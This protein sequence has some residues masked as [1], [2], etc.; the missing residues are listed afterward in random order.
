MGEKERKERGEERENERRCVCEGVRKQKGRKKGE[1]KEER[2][3]NRQRNNRNMDYLSP[4]LIFLWAK[5]TTFPRQISEPILI[6][7]D[8]LKFTNKMEAKN[9]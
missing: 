7:S 8:W 3:S 6:L 2:K 9:L 5:F 4:Q 1:K